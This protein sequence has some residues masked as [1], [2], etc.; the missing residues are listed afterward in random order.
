MFTAAVRDCLFATRMPQCQHG[1]HCR[2]KSQALQHVTYSS[3]AVGST[4]ID[5]SALKGPPYPYELQYIKKE[6][7]LTCTL[8]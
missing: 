5:F 8:L 4:D 1:R 7:L 2:A 3:R 6:K